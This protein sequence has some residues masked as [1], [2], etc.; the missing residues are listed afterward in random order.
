MLKAI[1]PRMLRAGDLRDLFNKLG[2]AKSVWGGV[3]AE[4]TLLGANP[5]EIDQAVKYAI[6]SLN[7]NN[8]LILSALVSGLLAP[9]ITYK[10]RVAAWEKYREI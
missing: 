10:Y 3:N 4:V 2:G 6:E 8:G 5:E 7:G 9:E 1:A